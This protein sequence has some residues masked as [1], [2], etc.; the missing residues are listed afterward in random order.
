MKFR[1]KSAGL[2]SAALILTYTRALAQE[3]GKITGYPFRVKLI[4]GALY[5]PLQAEIRT[6][7]QATG[8]KIEILSRKNHFELNR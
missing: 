2:I 8:A 4:G 6:W 3:Q 5:E 7:E 1:R